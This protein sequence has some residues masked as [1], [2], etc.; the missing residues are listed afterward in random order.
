MW[1][2]IVGVWLSNGKG[3][4]GGD[5]VSSNVQIELSIFRFTFRVFLPIL[6]TRSTYQ[7]GLVVDPLPF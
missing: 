6:R 5:G 4:G 2:Q 7:T 1:D 3:T